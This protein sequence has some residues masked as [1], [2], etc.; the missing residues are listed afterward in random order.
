[1]PGFDAYDPAFVRDPYP[2]YA[3]L[4]HEGPFSDESWGLT[5]F[6]R[7]R[8]VA[9]ILRDRRFGRDIRHVLPL[10]RIDRRTYPEHLPS[11]YRMIRGS[12]I[13]LEPPEHTRIRSAVN[14]SFT[15]SRAEVKRE[16]ITALATDLFERAA[17]PGHFD[18]VAEY[19]APIPVAVI[20]DLMGIPGE[21]QR[22]LLAWSHAIVRVFDLNVTPDE[23]RAAERAVEEFSGYLRTLVAERRKAPGTD[24]ISELVTTA[25][26]PDDDLVATCILILNAGHEATVHAIGNGILAL[27][28]HPEVFAA[29][30]ADP[31]LLPTATDELLRWDPPLQMFERWVLEDLEWEGVRLRTGDKVGLLFGAANHDPTVFP[32]PERIDPGRTDNPHL[33]FGLGTHFCLGAPLARVEIE[34]ALGVLVRRVDTLVPAL[35][36]PPRT[37]SLV[38]RGV[39]EL[40][41]RVTANPAPPA[42]PP[43]VS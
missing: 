14:R 16:S 37:P 25:G 13:D 27:A 28:R 31:D 39:D 18:A 11:W 40:P 19:A 22:D 42:P 23:E 2:T 26:L 43:G 7:H 21:R 6:S 34:E 29:L 10:D 32:D 15:K 8:D 1:M 17:T 5:F 30:R 9:G 3:R 24:L 4:R 20:A 12:F 38:F 35:D 41:V 36:E 33:A